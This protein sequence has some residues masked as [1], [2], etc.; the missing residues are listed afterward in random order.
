FNDIDD[1]NV[2]FSDD[3]TKVFKQSQEK[4]VKIREDALLLFGFKTRAKGLPD[5]NATIKFINAILDNGAGLETQERI[6][7]IKLNV[8]NYHLTV[9]ILPPYKPESVNETQELFDLIPVTTDIA[10]SRSSNEVC[11]KSSCNNIVEKSVTNLPQL[12]SIASTQDQSNNSEQFSSITEAKKELPKSLISLSTEYLIKCESDIEVLI[13]LL[14]Q[15]FQMSQEKLEQWRTKIA[16]EMRD[17]Q[18]YW[19]KECKSMDETDFLEYKRNFE[20][21]MKVP[22]TLHKKE[23]KS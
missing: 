12:S 13:F 22:T 15:K 19:K 10:T 11:E 23:L 18:N 14:Q 7:A 2:L 6:K 9:P 1:T 21:K 5:L 4:I 3:V 8:P 17:N 16:F 20:T